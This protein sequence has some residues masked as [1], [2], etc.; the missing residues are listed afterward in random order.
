[1][2]MYGATES[3]K[4]YLKDKLT[5]ADIEVADY[6]AIGL[7]VSHLAMDLVDGAGLLIGSP[8]VL[9]GPHPGIVLPIYLANAIKPG[10]KFAGIFGSYSWGTMMVDKIK[11]MLPN[12]KETELLEPVLAK[13][14]PKQEDFDAM[15]K[16]VEKIKGY[17]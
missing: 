1:M 13:G 4:N 9:T 8:T 12:L 7:N 10:L 5:Q 17:F 15:D 6:D 2:S 3:M 14:T 16:M 11:A